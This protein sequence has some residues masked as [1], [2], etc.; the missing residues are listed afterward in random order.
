MQRAV[1]I[2]TRIRNVG[3][4]EEIPIA[5]MLDFQPK[6]TRKQKFENIFIT[7]C[8]HYKSEIVSLYLAKSHF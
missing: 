2:T 1:E 3:S 8:I 6:Y 4:E 5:N 7:P